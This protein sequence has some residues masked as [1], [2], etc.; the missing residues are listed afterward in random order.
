MYLIRHETD[1]PLAK[2]GEHLGGRDHATVLHA[3]SAIERKL[4]EDV[5]MRETLTT[6]RARLSGVASG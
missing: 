6:L 5:T 2:I 4:R 3:L 1:A